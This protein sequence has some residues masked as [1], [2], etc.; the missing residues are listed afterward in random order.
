MH[1]Q[2]PLHGMPQDHT[3]GSTAHQGA[4]RQTSVAYVLGVR[5]NSYRSHKPLGFPA[6][7]RGK[8]MLGF[9]QDKSE[10]GQYQFVSVERVGD[11]FG[12][13]QV[14]EATQHLNEAVVNKAN[15]VYDIN[16]YGSISSLLDNVHV[17]AWTSEAG[18]AQPGGAGVG[19]GGGGGVGGAGPSGGPSGGG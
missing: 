13:M 19:G 1:G 18:F 7:T 16:D 9:Y 4:D 3:A 8:E 6:F 5:Y 12:Q 17:Y 15:V 10:S 2:M 11:D 14:M